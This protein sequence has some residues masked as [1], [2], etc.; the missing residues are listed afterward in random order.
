MKKFAVYLIFSFLLSVLLSSCSSNTSSEADIFQYKGSY[1]GDNSAVNKIVKQLSHNKELSQISLETKKE[2]Y[3][4]VLEYKD[5]DA[6][7]IDKEMKKTVITNSTYM[8]VL[9]QNVDWI[10]FKFTDQEFSVTR[11]N[12][13]KWYGKELYKFTNKKDLKDFIQLHLK[14]ENE[15]NQC[16]Q[17]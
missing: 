14:D 15:V 16:F 11:E 12:L 4:V 9:I 3:G 17:K 8:F 6:T 1:I 7:E 2:P 10:T 13:E 5:I